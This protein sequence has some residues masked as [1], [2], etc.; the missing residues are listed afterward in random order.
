MSYIHPLGIVFGIIITWALMRF[1]DRVLINRN[2]PVTSQYR[3]EHATMLYAVD[4]DTIDVLTSDGTKARVRVLG[5]DAPESLHPEVERNCPA[6]EKATAYARNLCQNGM[7]IW[8]ERD[9]ENVDKYGRLLRHVWLGCPDTA[10]FSDISMA[11]AMLKSGNARPQLF[12]P[13]LRHMFTI[14]RLAITH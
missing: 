10:K 9:V 12:I 1:V 7:S 5:I 3:F 13:N 2:A 14:T 8:L 4:G 11:A 6:G